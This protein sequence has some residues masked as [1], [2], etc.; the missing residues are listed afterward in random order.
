MPTGPDATGAPLQRQRRRDALLISLTFS[1][2][3]VDALSY[4]GLG[5]IFTANM[6]GNT[7]FL[8][9]GIGEG[10]VG[11]AARSV[12]ALAGFAFGAFAAGGRLEPARDPDPWPRVVTE[13]LWIELALLVVFAFVW[14]GL[15]GR[16]A[17]A[18]T[19]GLI[20]LGSLAMGMQSAAGR[21]LAVPGVTSNVLTMAMTGLMAE[22]A[23]LGI[24]GPHLRRWAAA[25][26]AMGSGAALGAVLFRWALPWLP[27]AVVGVVAAV[28]LAASTASRGPRPSPPDASGPTD[29]AIRPVNP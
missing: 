12:V 1:T 20:A 16:P 25:I 17:G 24:S 7:V 15:G 14:S 21:K 5:Q 9:I 4:L 27:W 10:N 26:V 6:T 8:A 23:A 11:T 13:I 18:A 19:Y 3:I 2:G 29:A 28:A 22:L